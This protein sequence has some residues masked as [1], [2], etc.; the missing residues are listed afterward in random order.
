M[1]RLA[2]LIIIVTLPIIAFFQYKKYTKFNP[3][4]IY[5]YPVSDSIDIH[6][7][8]PLM[9]EKY[10]ENVYRLE[11]LARELWYDKGLDIKFPDP[12]IAGSAVELKF[13]G[14]LWATTRVLQEKLL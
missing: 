8:D 12:A 9:V 1:K 4:S 3:P 13:Y 6:Y 2:W 11:S 14:Q 10:Y 7:Y 5:E